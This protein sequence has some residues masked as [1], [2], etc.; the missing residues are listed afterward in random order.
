M[1]SA[2]PSGGWFRSS[3]VIPGLGF[4]LGTRCQMFWL[5]DPR[6]PGAL[7]PRKRP[8]TTL[9][10]SLVMQNGRPRMVFGTPGGDQQDQWTLQFFLNMVVFGMDVQDAIDMPAFHTVHFPG[11]FYP[12]KARPGEMLVEGRMSPAVVEGLRERGHRVTVAG[13]WSLNYTTAVLHDPVRGLL[14]GGAS[15]RGERNYAVGW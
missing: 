5:H 3:P 9:S 15:S 4:S 11:S 8:R 12:R 1:F 10:P 14:E 2:T 13:E 6:H 7:V